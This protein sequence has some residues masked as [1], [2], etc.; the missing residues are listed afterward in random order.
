M[1][2]STST[3]LAGT[4]ISFGNDWVQTNKPN[5][6]IVVAGLGVALFFDGID[7]FSPQVAN[8]LA[9]IM[10]VTI[11]FTP[12]DGKSPAQT[13]VGLIQPKPAATGGEQ[14]AAMEPASGSVGSQHGMSA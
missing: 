11:L 14:T 2:A 6:R 13:V 12:I 10:F 9:A 8:G 7:K 5:L 3:V 1:S 4:A